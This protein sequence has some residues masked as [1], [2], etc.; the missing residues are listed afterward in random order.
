MYMKSRLSERGNEPKTS[1]VSTS[2]Q[3]VEDRDRPSAIVVVV[4]RLGL[5]WLV[6][7]V[8]GFY[9]GALGWRGGAFVMLAG[10][11]G[12]VAG[13]LLMGITEYRRVMRRPW[14]SV[15]PLEDDDEW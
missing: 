1:G 9:G 10:V 11:C 4:A 8:V 5:V 3:R 2:F 14:P 13:H 12:N 15:R 7:L 6:L